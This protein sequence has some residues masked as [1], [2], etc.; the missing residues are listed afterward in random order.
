MKTVSVFNVK[1]VKAK[2]QVFGY[3]LQ[4]YYK[5]LKI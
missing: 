1:Y 5:V 4:N 3:F 2:A